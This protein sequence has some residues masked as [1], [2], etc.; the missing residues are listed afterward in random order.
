MFN[1]NFIKNFVLKISLRFSGKN[2]KFP[3]CFE[4][5]D[6]SHIEVNDSIIEGFDSIGKVKNNSRIVANS[7]IIRK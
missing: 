2:K 5:S 4:A 6:N 3:S 7:S 1:L